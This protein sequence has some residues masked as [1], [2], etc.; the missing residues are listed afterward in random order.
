MNARRLSTSNAQAY[1]NIPAQHIEHLFGQAQQQ[2]EGQYLELAGVYEPDQLRRFQLPAHVPLES[3]TEIDNWLLNS[4]F[5]I[6]SSEDRIADYWRA[7]GTGQVAMTSGIIGAKAIQIVCT[8]GQWA[9]V[10]QEQ[11]IEIQAG[12]KFVFQGWYHTSGAG[13][14]APVSG[15]GLEAIG[16]RADA[17]TETL[18]AS[19][20]VDTGGNPRRLV[21]RGSFSQRVTKVKFRAIV[22]S[23][24]AFPM[25]TPVVI[26]AM[27]FDR[28]DTPKEW[29]PFPLDHPPYVRLP[30]I[31][32]P[33]VIESGTRVQYVELMRNFWTEAVPTRVGQP[34]LMWS[35]GTLDP[36]PAP[37]A[38]GFAVYGEGGTFTEVDF[39]DKE[40]TGIWQAGYQGSTPGIRG[41]GDDAPDV[42]GPWD[43]GFLNWRNW[44]E[45]G[46]T[47]VPEAMT[48]FGN[49]L[50]VVLQKQDQLSQ[51]KRFLLI[52]EPKQPRPYKTFLRA[53]AM[54]ELPGLSL[55]T[56]IS[57]AE[58]RRSDYQWLY[59]GN[60]RSEWAFRLYYDYFMID[61][62]GK[63]LITR[64]DYG[65]LLPMLMKKYQVESG[66]ALQSQTRLFR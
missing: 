25:I 13:L 54:L 58:F 38:D 21:L 1:L 3:P 60:G 43:I 30:R 40:W 16:Y 7:E 63:R 41:L 10:Y 55:S 24:V 2:L 57:R 27:L 64:E 42:W 49:K 32:G 9:G 39:W 6:V 35:G 51:W 18:Q 50:A 66:M 37:G 23:S 61:F 52:V 20:D 46:Q 53:V 22:T 33:V 11:D 45:D 28:S 36:T 5:E 15:F 8:P 19:F 29:A 17:T 59:L 62:G 12:E 14:T 34:R 4:S 47:W 31:L 48:A 65:D 44:F 26:D 56:S